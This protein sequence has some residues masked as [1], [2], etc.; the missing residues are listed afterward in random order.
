MQHPPNKNQL[1]TDRLDLETRLRQARLTLAASEARYVRTRSPVEGNEIGR[2]THEVRLLELQQ[3]G[4]DH[5]LEV[6]ANPPPVQLSTTDTAELHRQKA[7]LLQAQRYRHAQHQQQVERVRAQHASATADHMKIYLAN[8]FA[9]SEAARRKL[10]SEDARRIANIDAQ[11]SEL[12]RRNLTF[13]GP[14]A[15]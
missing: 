6:I 8:A 5:Q 3:R 7:Q 12:E 14:S 10:D 11:L 4:I 13:D 9:G 15:A 2:L 1:T